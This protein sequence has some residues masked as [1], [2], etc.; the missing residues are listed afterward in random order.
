MLISCI[1][2]LS[3]SPQ[4]SGIFHVPGSLYPCCISISISS[5][6]LEPSKS[7]AVVVVGDATSRELLEQSR[8]RRP[9][10]IIY[11][12]MDS[13]TLTA[14]LV[15]CMNCPSAITEPPILTSTTFYCHRRQTRSTAPTLRKLPSTPR[16]QIR[17]PP[18]SP[19]IYY[20]TV[21]QTSGA[22]TSAQH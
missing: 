2:S 11:I 7:N 21:Q 15:K 14:N 13:Q 16:Q 1:G 12:H 4:R 20:V 22:T 18:F 5:P 19:S 8:S 3:S 17:R 10:W 6:Q 9:S